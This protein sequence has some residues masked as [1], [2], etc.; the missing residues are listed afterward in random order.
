MT[1]IFGLSRQIGDALDKAMAM[2]SALAHFGKDSQSLESDRSWTMG[3]CRAH[4]LPEDRMPPETAPDARYLVVADARLT[5]RDRLITELGGT[6]LDQLS[7]AELVAQAVSTWGVDAFV[8]IHGEFAV[9]AWDRFDQALILARDIIG[10]RPL[11]YAQSYGHFAFASM[12]SGLHALDWVKPRADRHSYRRFLRMLGP[13]FGCTHFAGISRVMPAHYAIVRGGE[14]TQRRYWVPDLEPLELPSQHDYE[15]RLTELLDQAI[16]ASLRGTEGTVAAH[17]SA[18]FD[19]TAVVTTAALQLREEGRRL[20]AL[21]AA[22]AL[23]GIPTLPEHLI[24]DESVEAGI[25]AALHP[26]IDHVVVRRNRHALTDIERAAR[27]YPS[28]FLNLCNAPWIDAIHDEVRGRR[29][30][31]LLTGSMGNLT[32]SESGTLALCE[33]FRS[34]RFRRW[35]PIA[36]GLV[37]NGTMRWR[38]VL[39]NSV[40][41]I[42]PDFIYALGMK[43]TGDEPVAIDRYHMLRQNEESAVLREV[44]AEN[45]LLSRFDRQV[46]LSTDRMTR[47]SVDYR[48]L[49]LT[50]DKGAFSKAIWGEWGIDERDPTADRRLIEF[51]LRV[52]VERLIWRGNP[53]AILRAVLADRAP[54]SLVNSRRKGVQSADWAAALSE[55]LPHMQDTAERIVM[56]GAADGLI[57]IEKMQESLQNLSQ[58]DLSRRGADQAEAE[59][60]YA[61]LRALSAATHFNRANASNY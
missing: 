58:G 5:D 21:T 6:N 4:V 35:W 47:T 8:R 32:I 37:R 3:A 25:T 28:P 56:S 51:A 34:G 12:P 43:A 57:E 16:A 44:E 42:L 1:A 22:P 54:P 9:A 55:A 27:I 46:V 11:F 36:R 7:D 23:N 50:S 40:A 19:S 2:Q 53:R 33:L 61:L 24:A 41:P 39:W 26:N 14:V 38:G 10:A 15:V 20:V 59:Y 52:P 18:G 13:G 30:K 29:I 48:L 45:A 17:L 49:A 60:R 31:V